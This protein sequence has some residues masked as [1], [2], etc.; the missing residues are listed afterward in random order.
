M[1]V[2]FCFTQPIIPVGDAHRERHGTARKFKK[3]VR[4]KR[5]LLEE[6]DE[7][8]SSSWGSLTLSST[9]PYAVYSHLAKISRFT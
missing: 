3:T 4:I 2:N 1:N 9:P 7:V 6:L 5:V 8:L